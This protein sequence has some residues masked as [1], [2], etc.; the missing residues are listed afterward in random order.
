MRKATLLYWGLLTCTLGCQKETILNMFPVQT[1]DPLPI[2]QSAAPVFQPGDT[3]SGSAYAYKNQLLW[4]AR[5]SAFSYIKNNRKYWVA[6]LATVAPDLLSLREVVAFEGLPDDCVGK[7]FFPKPSFNNNSQ[8][9]SAGY[10]RLYA[11]GDVII[12]FYTIDTTALD[13]FVRIDR[14]DRGRKYISGSYR[15]TF[16]LMPPRF[17]PYNPLQIKFTSGRFRAKYK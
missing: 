14:I 8:D 12:D 13:N 16:R 9:A 10:V 17:D 11:D 6:E 1:P 2:P 7:M 3:S 5:A 15:L 4:R